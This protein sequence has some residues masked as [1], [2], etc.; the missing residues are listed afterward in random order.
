MREDWL[1]SDAPGLGENTA[2]VLAELG[3]DAARY[4]ELLGQG[5]I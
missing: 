2:E 5:I 4:D 3:L 1:R